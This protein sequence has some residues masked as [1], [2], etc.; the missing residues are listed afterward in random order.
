MIGSLGVL[1]WLQSNVRRLMQK[2]TTPSYDPDTDSNEALSDSLGQVNS[3]LTS[4][5]QKDTSPSFDADTDSLEAIREKID[6][7]PTSFTVKSSQSAATATGKIDD[8]DYPNSHGFVS[9]GG[10]GS[11]QTTAWS[12][13]DASTSKDLWL[14]HVVV[15]PSIEE[16]SNTLK[17]RVFIGVGA[18]GSESTIV[19]LPVQMLKITDVGKPVCAVYALPIPIKIPSGSRVAVKAFYSGYSTGNQRLDIALGWMS[20][21]ET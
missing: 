16:T 9:V 19:S 4:A 11:N 17:G 8:V 7:L 15:M 5:K 10:A 21:L 12:E 6:T 13:Y 2:T 1:S 3:S 20:G 18:A 14:S